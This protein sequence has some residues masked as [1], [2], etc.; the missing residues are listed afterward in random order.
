MSVEIKIAEIDASSGTEVII[1]NNGFLNAIVQNN[2]DALQ[3]L[4][5]QVGPLYMADLSVDSQGRVV[6]KNK[7]FAQKMQQKLTG[8]GIGAAGAMTLGGWGCGGGCVNI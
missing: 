8:G 7:A 6:V 3:L 2:Q 4:R 1:S 5:D